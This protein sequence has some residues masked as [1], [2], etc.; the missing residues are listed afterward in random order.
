MAV[1]TDP[2]YLPRSTPE[3]AVHLEVENGF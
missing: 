1:F 2:G 3:E